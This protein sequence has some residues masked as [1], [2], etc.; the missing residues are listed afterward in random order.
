M[1]VLTDN[2]DRFASGSVV[3]RGDELTTLTVSR[4]RRTRDRTVVSFE[5]VTD[6]DGAEAL[7]GA[8]LV[9]ATDQARPLEADEH[10]D[11]DLLG[12]AVVTEQGTE[13]GTVT[14]VLHQPS[15]ELL[16]VEGK[17]KE[18]LIP[19][20]RSIVKHVERRRRITIDPPEGLLD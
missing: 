17:G 11:H 3:L 18:L 6:R 8:E 20:V 7:R 16:L 19:L 10:W 5:E 15:G 9:I 2:P 14:D 4:T 1:L 13:V 12:C